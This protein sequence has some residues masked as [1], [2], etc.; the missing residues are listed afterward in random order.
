MFKT[1]NPSLLANLKIL[2]VA[3]LILVVVICSC[4]VVVSNNK[5]SVDAVGTVDSTSAF[6][7]IVTSVYPS[8]SIAVSQD[9]DF[10]FTVTAYSSAQM[11]ITIAGEIYNLSQ[12][13]YL[14]T[15][16]DFTVSVTMPSTQEEIEAIGDITLTVTF[17][18]QVITST[19]ATV[20]YTTQENVTEYKLEVDNYVTTAA[21]DIISTSTYVGSTITSSGSL[22]QMS[23]YEVCQITARYADA[24]LSTTSDNESV[25]YI[26]TLASGTMDYIVGQV[27][28]YDSSEGEFV[29][30]YN[31]ASGLRVKVE[32]SQ[33]VSNT[34]LDYNSMQVVSSTNSNGELTLTFQ[35]DWAVPYSFNFDT[36]NYYTSYGESYNVSSFDASTIAFTFYYTTS[37]SGTI[38]VSG[39]DIVSS[40]SVTTS[41]ENE[42][43][44]I[45]MPLITKGEYF[46]YTLSYDSNGYMVLTIQN[47]QDSLTD[48]VIVLDPGHGGVDS[49]ALGVNDT[50]YESTVNLILAAKIKE[51]LE[52]KG[53][54]VYLTRYSDTYVSLTDRKN[55]SV[56]YNA[57][58]F[59]S[60][61]ANG[62]VN[63]ED[64]GVSAY[65]YK[66]MSQ[67]LAESIY[68]ELFDTFYNVIYEGDSSVYNE[69]NDGV[70]YYPFS[71]TRIENCPSVLLEVGYMTNYDECV[72]IVESSNSDALAIAIADGIE[73]YYNLYS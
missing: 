9:I 34:T 28:V 57:D 69:I 73:N 45:T 64:I 36:Q 16:S 27:S 54:T 51:E 55:L 12:E 7:Q 49:G 43:V 32:D 59:I 60:I 6:N 23:G 33:I 41:V 1:D 58:L 50:V 24:R 35:T 40:A 61:H 48:A 13:T 8:G 17:G 44:T 63:S 19:I 46:G 42:S 70:R 11:Y 53:A 15:Y 4:V 5:S 20:S 56:T 25:P 2:A 14:G 65:Y 67:Q 71:V 66:A 52:A 72:K 62:S 22:S 38:D 10:D 47:Q 68:D 3:I 39:S 37:L 30:F 21:S 29:D 18:N 31:L 26:S